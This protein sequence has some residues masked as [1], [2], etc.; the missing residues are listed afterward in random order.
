MIEECF[1]S[2]TTECYLIKMCIMQ[3]VFLDF[4]LGLDH[5]QIFLHHAC[6]Q[7]RRTLDRLLTCFKIYVA[8][9]IS[10]MSFFENC[11]AYNHAWGTMWGS[12]CLWGET[13]WL[14]KQAQSRKSCLAL[15]NYFCLTRL[16][17][18]LNSQLSFSILVNEWEKDTGSEMLMNLWHLDNVSE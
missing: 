10:D 7:G 17:V 11:S 13:A 12:V 4:F 3:C 16:Y 18:H 5:S 15:W 9:I 8:D 6:Y 1:T 14:C 2:G